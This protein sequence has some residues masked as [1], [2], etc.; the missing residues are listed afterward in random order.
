MAITYTT[1]T[2]A[3]PSATQTESPQGTPSFLPD[4]LTTESVDP[5]ERAR[6][7]LF[8]LD[9]G[10]GHD[11]W[12]KILCA[13]KEA[14]LSSQ[15][16]AE[17]SKKS[18][19]YSPSGFKATWNSIVVGKKD[20]ITPATLYA[21]ALDVGWIDPAPGTKFCT[22][23]PANLDFFTDE[24]AAQTT[25]AVKSKRAELEKCFNEWPDATAEHGYLVAKG[26][27]P[28][29]LKVVPAASP[30]I[31][32]GQ[33]VAGW[34]AVPAR[35]PEGE[36]TTV[37]FISQVPGVVKLNAPGIPFDG[38]MYV[39]G[40]ISPTNPVYVCEGIGQAHACVTADNQSAAVCS[41][42][43]TRIRSAAIAIR[44]WYP[45]AL[46]IVI[47]ADRCQESKAQE[48]ASEIGGAWVGMPTGKPKNYDANDYL[49]EHSPAA[50][51][52]LLHNPTYPAKA[53]NAI[54]SP[55]EGYRYL[56]SKG[57]I[58]VRTENVVI[59]LRNRVGKIPRLGF[60]EA[61]SEVV[62]TMDDGSS[63]P[64]AD[65]DYTVWQM[66]IE[67]EGFKGHIPRQMM[68][69]A[70]EA[71][72]RE[73]TF[74][75]LRQWASELQWDGHQRVE[76]FAHKYLGVPDTPFARAVSQYVWSALAGRAME[77]GCKA[78]YV[79]VLVGPEG[80]GKTRSVEAFAPTPQHFT[81]IDLLAKPD[82]LARK[83]RGV[84]V[85]EWSEMRGAKTRDEEAIKDFITRREEHHVPKY[86]EHAVRYK[87]R[88][89]IIGT[90]NDLGVLPSYGDAR[91]WFPL[92]ITAKIDVDAIAADRE[93]LWSEGIHLYKTGGVHWQKAD[94]LAPDVRD[95]Y[96]EEDP[97]RNPVI[98]WLE[99]I[100]YGSF[101]G[102]HGVPNGDSEFALADLASELQQKGFNKPQTNKL[103]HLLRSL[104]Y[105]S[106]RTVKNG[107][108]RMLWRKKQP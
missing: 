14:G 72:A 35:T 83:T 66:Q 96:R 45:A 67:R 63:R 28:I 84:V 76:T 70:V 64:L 101:G 90:T 33:S 16:V 95:D 68:L 105:E 86:R 91:R 99:A 18:N 11:E 10:C 97:L 108:K 102:T 71:V 12:F 41:F 22:S 5:S 75:S 65:N 9:P 40:E 13:A 94:A 31:V 58:A 89:I 37:Q 15:V 47:V 6:S 81:S 87:R 107:L 34:L 17:W 49:R 1:K 53:A 98:D 23:A 19:K 85:A 48:T 32:S 4:H 92:E 57:E 51:A 82:D 50:L 27:S 77:P 46:K 103:A 38:G 55:A 60:D 52:A 69:D 26:I 78:D 8:S 93:Q 104:G 88:Y 73:N 29:G 106:F 44:E 56:S 80:T 61:L 43:A 24:S 79:L 62:V 3:S 39:V 54:T 2:H 100:P 7:A 36:L 74:D 21:K 30:L 25:A 42:G 20:G 59:A